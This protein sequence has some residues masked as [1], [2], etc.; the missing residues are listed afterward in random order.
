MI[1]DSNIV[2][3]AFEPKCRESGLESF[4][5]QGD[6]S[7]SVIT[8]EVLG[9]WRNSDAEYERFDL[10]FDAPHVIA[11]SSEIIDRAIR[12]RRQRSM[13]LADA[14]IAATASLHRLP[15]VTPITPVIFNGLLNW[16]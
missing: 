16:S 7:V 8:R 3:Y 5:L 15:L 1:L 13:G 4:L 2:I 6:F 11:I 14:I 9:Y 10:F 12:L